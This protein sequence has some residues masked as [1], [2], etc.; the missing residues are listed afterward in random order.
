MAFIQVKKLSK[1]I[2]QAKIA[3]FPNG[4]V[5]LN[6]PFINNSM[7]T[8]DIC[9]HHQNNTKVRI[10]I[11]SLYITIGQWHLI[12]VTNAQEVQ[13]SG[14]CMT[15]TTGQTSRIKATFPV[16]KSILHRRK[17]SVRHL[18]WRVFCPTD[19]RSHLHGNVQN[20]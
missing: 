15:T 7:F 10:I 17:S 14:Q 5:R 16:L 3:A 8:T 1:I 19:R 12:V 9:E 6:I 11:Q 13:K 2:Q 4:T 20:K 18:L